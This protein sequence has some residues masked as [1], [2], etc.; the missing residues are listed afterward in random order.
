[1]SV[2]RDKNERERER[3]KEKRERNTTKNKGGGRSITIKRDEIERDGA[4][5]TCVCVLSELCKLSKITKK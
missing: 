4:V 5:N 1:M 3:E 2:Q